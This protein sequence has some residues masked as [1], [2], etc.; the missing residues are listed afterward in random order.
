MRRGAERGRAREQPG[1]RQER[2]ATSL[3]G[4]LL[5]EHPTS[6][7]TQP[8][9]PMSLADIAFQVKATGSANSGRRVASKTPDFA[10]AARQNSPSATYLPASGISDEAAGCASSWAVG[11]AFAF[12]FAAARFARERRSVSESEPDSDA[13]SSYSLSSSD[14]GGELTRSSDRRPPKTTGAPSS[15]PCAAKRVPRTRG[16]SSSSSG[17]AGGALTQRR[18]SRPSPLCPR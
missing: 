8:A 18:P 11:A 15:P 10:S 1:E 14:S 7:L 5:R 2:A 16:G 12:A 3:H 9:R 17:R 6:T 4:S 13:E